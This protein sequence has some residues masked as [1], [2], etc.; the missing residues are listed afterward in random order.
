MTDPEYDPQPCPDGGTTRPPDALP[1]RVFLVGSPRSRTTVSQ[2]IVA[3]ACNLA[4]MRSTNWY[5]GHPITLVLNGPVGE[6]REAMRP[7]AIQRVADHVRDTT[8]LLLPAVFR[9]QD[10]FDRLAT[11]T[12]SVGWLEKT[13]IHVLAIPEIEGDVPGAR[14]VHLVRDPMGVVA[15]LMRRARDHPDMFGASYQRVQVNAETIWRACTQ[16]TLDC[17]DKP[18][19][20]V[21]YSESFV[22]DPETE[23]ARVA[24]FLDVPY[25]APDHSDR[26]AAARLVVPSHRAW[27]KDAVG[28]VRRIEHDD[29]IRMRDLSLE[30][31]ALWKKVRSV[32]GISD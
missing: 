1:C 22:D 26:I 8:G 16:A 21:V 14:F 28:P 2:N 4:T 15:S 10:A 17:R 3:L 12:G 5:L 19:H 23:A 25:R 29:A 20:I 9:L 7:R 13:P 24:K 30:T 18:N 27:K 11:E 31:Q 32:M 6:T